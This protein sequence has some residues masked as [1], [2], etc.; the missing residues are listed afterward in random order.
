MT[1]AIYLTVT[2]G[3]ISVSWAELTD[4]FGLFRD[5]WDMPSSDFKDGGVYGNSSLAHG[6]IFKHGVFDN[7]IDTYQLALHFSSVNG[8]LA[9]IDELEELTDNLFEELE[10]Q[11]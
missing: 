4:C 5:G 10:E 6:Q 2:D 1:R 3:D 8:L 11:N 9:D 7:V